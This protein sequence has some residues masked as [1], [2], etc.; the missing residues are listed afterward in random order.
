MNVIEYLKNHHND[1]TIITDKI[2]LAQF[3]AV[4]NNYK[5][6][7]IIS[8]NLLNIVYKGTKILHTAQVLQEKVCVHNIKNLD[9]IIR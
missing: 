8:S 1:T 9:L 4:E 7:S 6:A 3:H 5:H 2:V